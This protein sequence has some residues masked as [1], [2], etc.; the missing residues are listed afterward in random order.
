MKLTKIMNNMADYNYI[1]MWNNAI[2]IFKFPWESTSCSWVCK[3]YPIDIP[4]VGR[5]V[6]PFGSGNQQL[7]PNLSAMVS[8]SPRFLLSSYF[9]T[10]FLLS[11]WAG[12]TLVKLTFFSQFS[13]K[14]VS[15]R[16]VENCSEKQVSLSVYRMIMSFGYRASSHLHAPHCFF[17]RVSLPASLGV[18]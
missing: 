1:K 9:Y 15:D 16:N 5:N 2:E 6:K 7:L 10:I 18:C 13:W 12:V 17:L 8:I 3:P 14:H 11:G 4:L